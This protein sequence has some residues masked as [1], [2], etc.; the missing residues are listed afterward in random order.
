MI[1]RSTDK[2]PYDN[3]LNNAPTLNAVVAS[4][5]SNAVLSASSIVMRDQ[6]AYDAAARAVESEAAFEE[7][8][9]LVIKNLYKAHGKFAEIDLLYGNGAITSGVSI[10][11]STSATS[12]SGNAVVTITYASWAPAIFSGYE[13]AKLDAYV[14][15][16]QVNTPGTPYVIVSV[17]VVPAS[18]TVGGVVTVSSTSSGDI[19]A[20]INACNGATAVDFYWFGAFGNNMTGLKGILSP[21]LYPGGSLFGINASTYSLWAPN[22]FDC[23]NSQLTFSKLQQ[24]IALGV[25]RGLDESVMALV[26][27]VTFADLVNEQAGA[28]RYDS[29]Y[30]PKQNE[31]GSEAL[32]YWG[33]SGKIEVVPHMFVHQGEAMVVPPA[34]LMKTGSTDGITPALQGM[35]EELFLQSPTNAAAEMRLFSNFALLALTPAKCTLVKNIVNSQSA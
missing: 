4:Q 34:E 28:R 10:A 32:T 33:P 31:N 20:L 23:G 16:S 17:N 29:S 5:M 27:P 3:K 9:G 2:K 13:N 19:T 6:V 7:A 18:T 14:S 24:A 12:S 15:G 8:V 22:T 30:K 25:S 26:S 11:Q 21:S 35:G 1:Y